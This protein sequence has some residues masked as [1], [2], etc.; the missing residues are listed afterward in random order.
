MV[1][2]ET[3][4]FA[5]DRNRK[6][7]SCKKATSRSP[8]G[9]RGAACAAHNLR[10]EVGPRPGDLARPFAPKGPSAAVPDQ[11]GAA[12]PPGEAATSRRHRASS[13]E[14]RLPAGEAGCGAEGA[15]GRGGGAEGA[16][17]G[18]CRR[19]GGEPQVH[20]CLLVDHGLHGRRRWPPQPWRRRLRHPAAVAAEVPQRGTGDDMA[21]EAAPHGGPRVHARG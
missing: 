9:P 3:R 5:W 1:S 11:R 6:L 2:A 19:G 12:E 20:K 10:G 18:A 4:L 21:L 16:L 15:E 8:R 17:C 14:E 7:L 13:M